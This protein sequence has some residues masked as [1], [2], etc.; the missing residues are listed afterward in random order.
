[1]CTK[2]K[3]QRQQKTSKQQQQRH[4]CDQTNKP[5]DTRKPRRLGKKVLIARTAEETTPVA[6]EST[7]CSLETVP[8]FA[9]QR[10]RSRATSTFARARERTN[11]RA[12]ARRR[13]IAPRRLVERTN[14]YY[15]Y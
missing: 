8:L 15:Y 7:K 10:Q 13:T 2:I 1:M 4:K 6:Y 5:T 11:K 9:H 14:Y 3:L 12:R